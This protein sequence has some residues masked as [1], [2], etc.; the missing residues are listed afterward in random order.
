[1]KP[2]LLA[3]VAVLAMPF[4]FGLARVLH[5]ETPAPPSASAQPPRTPEELRR[6]LERELERHGAKLPPLPSGSAPP[7]ALPSPSASSSSGNLQDDLARRWAELSSTRL[8]RRD[9]HRAALIQEVGARLNDPGVQAELSLHATRLAEIARLQ[10][11]AQNAR[12][13][14]QRDKLLLRITKLSEREAERHRRRLLK[15]GAFEAPSASASAVTAPAPSASG[16]PR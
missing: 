11:L 7:P 6:H 3:A 8:Q 2:T 15:L 12:S 4:S 14:A 16:A 13:G 5:A 9:R 1:M 10:F